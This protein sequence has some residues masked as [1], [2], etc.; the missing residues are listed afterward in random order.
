M[1]EQRRAFGLKILNA[2]HRDIARLKRAGHVAEIHGNRFWN[3]SFLIMD[4]LRRHPLKKR[5]RVLEVG[6][7]WGLLG[8]Y[9]AKKF[10]ARVTGIDADGAVGAYLDLHAELNN[11]RMAFEKKRFSQLTINFLS[12]FD[13]LLGADICFWDELTPELFNMIRRA[14]RAG[15]RQVMIADP[16]RSPF[17][18][19]SERCQKT[20]KSAE[21]IEKWLKSPVRASGEILIVDLT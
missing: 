8:M 17:E 18:D 1:A 21:R 12:N 5:T 15:V 6:C 7:G 3:S 9:C 19:L 13:V 11:V 4:Y 14:R 2:S 10:D 20:F 16:C